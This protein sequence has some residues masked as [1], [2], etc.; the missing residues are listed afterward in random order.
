[1]KVYKQSSC[2]INANFCPVFVLLAILN[3]I[4]NIFYLQL[5]YQPFLVP[6]ILFSTISLHFFLICCRCFQIVSC[7]IRVF[8][9]NFFCQRY[10]GLTNFFISLT[11]IFQYLPGDV[12]V[13]F[14]QG[15]SSPVP[16][17]SPDCSWQQ[18]LHNFSLE[19]RYGQYMPK[20]LQ[21]FIN[22]G[23]VGSDIT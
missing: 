11:F 18:I 9:L 23:L 10:I 22:E 16:L 7:H 15:I 3:T 4:S 13:I 1:M 8:F 12:I 5:R 14:S 21:A 17:S 19:I 20:I 2:T 6:F